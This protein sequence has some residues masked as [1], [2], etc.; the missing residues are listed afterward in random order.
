MIVSDPA[1]LSRGRHS[2]PARLQLRGAH[3]PPRRKTAHP[4]DNPLDLV[5]GKHQLERT[6]DEQSWVFDREP[7]GLAAI[8]SDVVEVHRF[9]QIEVG[10]GVEAADKRLSVVVEIALNVE[11]GTEGWIDAGP[12][13]GVAPEAHVHALAA[14]VGDHRR[15]F[16]QSRVPWVAKVPSL[17]YSPPRQSGSAMIARRP[18]SLWIAM[19]CAPRAPVEARGATAETRSG[20][21]VAH[22]APGPADRAANC[23]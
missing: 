6:A 10:I 21:P 11:H 4:I 23:E 13:G 5:G 19:P 15:S 9:G 7:A 8:A 17:W 14:V 12:G 3:T 18:T 20:P 2:R 22:A 1:P 16:W